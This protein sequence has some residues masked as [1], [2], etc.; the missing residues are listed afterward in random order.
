MEKIIRELLFAVGEDPERE[1]LR[2]TPT[3]VAASMQELT[4]G[5]EK[6]PRKILLDAVFDLGHDQMVVCRDIRFYSLCEHHLLPFFG[7][8]HIGY[9]PRGKV[10]GLSKLVRLVEAFARR[11]QVQERLTGQIAETINAVLEPEGVGVVVEATHLCMA[12]RSVQQ[13]TSDIVTSSMLGRFEVHGPTREE[14]LQY[15]RKT[16][17]E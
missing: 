12:M 10:V 5:Y 17:S 15:V 11:L 16:G 4:S 8:C 2:R 6:D 13:D 7:R 9:I 14:F 3:R 1:G